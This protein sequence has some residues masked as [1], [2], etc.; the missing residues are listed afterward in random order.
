MNPSSPLKKEETKLAAASC[1]PLLCCPIMAATFCMFSAALGP[2]ATVVLTIA[3]FMLSMALIKP[4]IE[5]P[6]SAA[7]EMRESDN[8]SDAASDIP[9]T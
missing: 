7:V 4:S 5:S 2:K 9:R 8:A 1:K 6:F 3:S